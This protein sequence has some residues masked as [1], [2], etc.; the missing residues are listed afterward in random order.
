MLRATPSREEEQRAAKAAGIEH[1]PT[2]AEYAAMCERGS[3]YRAF[4]KAFKPDIV[5]RC[6][7]GKM[8][9]SFQVFNV[10]RMLREDASL[11]H[12]VGL[13]LYIGNPTFAMVVPAVWV[14]TQ[15]G[16]WI[17]TTDQGLD[18]TVVLMTTKDAS[19]HSYLEDWFQR[20]RTTMSSAI[21]AVAMKPIPDYRIS[22]DKYLESKDNLRVTDRD[23]FYAAECVED[24]N[25]GYLIMGVPYNSG[26]G[27]ID[28]M[29]KLVKD[30]D[31]CFIK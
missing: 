28:D 8:P 10:D 9:A 15:G 12:Q 17:E 14:V 18:D 25:G 22:L 13:S 27:M 16:I 21:K 1:A 29:D 30:Q 19:L 7:S 31:K 20:T 11:R 6:V 3:P 23:V 24:G 2:D 5:Q 4:L 26:P